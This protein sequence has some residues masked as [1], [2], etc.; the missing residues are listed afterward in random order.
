VSELLTSPERAT[1]RELAKRLRIKVTQA[2]GCKYCIHR[3]EGWGLYAC[4][5]EGR[6]FPLCLKTPGTSFEPDHDKLRGK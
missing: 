5:A 4:S 3:V 2:G 6:S 1:E